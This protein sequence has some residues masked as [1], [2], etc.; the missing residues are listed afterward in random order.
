MINLNILN[1][2][3]KYNWTKVSPIYKSKDTILLIM[4]KD[5]YWSIKIK[6]NIENYQY[7][8][9]IKISFSY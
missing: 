3:I 8:A 4:Y 5:E 1:A 6:Q 9:I 7:S 2:Y